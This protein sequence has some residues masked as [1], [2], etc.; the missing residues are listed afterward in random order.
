MRHSIGEV[1]C[2]AVLWL[3]WMLACAKTTPPPKPAAASESKS[4]PT[5]DSA[6]MDE[7]V[8]RLLTSF[9]NGGIDIAA[10][11]E[12]ADSSLGDRAAKTKAIAAS[13][14]SQPAGLARLQCIDQHKTGTTTTTTAPANGWGAHAQP[15]Q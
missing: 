15:K 6:A 14:V 1:G 8:D 13:C 10:F 4:T 9:G 11:N 3:A 2:A 5:N 12:Q 7:K